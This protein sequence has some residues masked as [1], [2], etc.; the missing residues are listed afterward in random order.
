MI[1]QI[2]RMSRLTCL[3][4]CLAVLDLAPAERDWWNKT[5]LYG[6]N[7][8]LRI[9]K[10]DNGQTG[11][12]LS[13]LRSSNPFLVNSL[14]VKLCIIFLYLQGDSMLSSPT[15][16]GYGVYRPENKQTVEPLFSFP[17]ND[18]VSKSWYP[19]YPGYG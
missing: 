19:G 7:M 13:I 16:Y 3:L 4:L 8:G 9:L 15:G 10:R 11:R 6:S 18:R 17:V 12:V 14:Q 1:T 2:W 5:G